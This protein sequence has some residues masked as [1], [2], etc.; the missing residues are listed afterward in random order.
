M[1]A[2][3]RGDQ[4]PAAVEVPPSV[5]TAAEYS[6]AMACAGASTTA[7]KSAASAITDERNMTLSP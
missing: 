3:R 2:G 6:P 4:E 1:E 7:S 5:P